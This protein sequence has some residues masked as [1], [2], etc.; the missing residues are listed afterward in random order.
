MES[1][2]RKLRPI[3]AAAWADA[4]R[5][6]AP[7]N[8]YCSKHRAWC[9]ECGYSFDIEDSDLSVSVCGG[10]IVCPHCLAELVMVQSWRRKSIEH[11]TYG[12][13]MRCGRWNVFRHYYVSYEVYK[14]RLSRFSD[15]FEMREV[16]QN[17][18]DDEG[19]EV[20]RAYGM[21][22]R[23]GQGYSD[24]NLNS[25][26]KVRDR[27]DHFYEYHYDD[28]V[29]YERWSATSVARRNGFGL[30]SQQGIVRSEHLRMLVSDRR[31]EQLV[32]MGQRNFAIHWYRN[33][34]NGRI[35]EEMLHAVK[36]CTRHGYIIDDASL[37]ADMVDALAYLGKDIHNPC[38]ICPKDLRAAH[39]KWVGRMGERKRRQ[40]VQQHE[41]EYAQEKRGLL[42]IQ[43]SGLGI[44]IRPLQSVQEFYDEGEAMHHC[45]Y[46]NEY[47]KK[48]DS[49]ILSVRDADG[50]R[51][52]TVEY[53]L[54]SYR[55][56]QDRGPCNKVPEQKDSIEQL[57]AGSVG[58]FKKA[59]EESKRIV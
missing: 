18:I 55:I 51:I 31:Y 52:A 38:Y 57:I 36:V 45:V 8:A 42:G 5:R 26:M 49:L 7:H 9:S 6:C 22:Y 3:S 32:K 13:L 50:A 33:S 16:L 11:T 21:V 1:L 43:L 54:R 34:D 39:D 44:V 37:W 12:F 19:H 2:S 41:Q 56:L 59:M 40:E 23:M 4:A 20:V 25:E 46:R 10:D 24:F 35:S 15:N 29:F 48:R 28:F 47:F 17:W 27:H 30:G 58:T 14:D 53:D